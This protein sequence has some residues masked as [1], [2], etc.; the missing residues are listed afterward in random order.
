MKLKNLMI[1]LVALFSTSQ[2]FA[3]N[4]VKN[5]T[6]SPSSAGIE[7]NQVMSHPLSKAEMTKIAKAEK[8]QVKAQKKAAFFAKL[9][10]KIDFKD[11]VE[12]WLWFGIFGW[13]ASILLYILAY[14]VP[15]L[16]IL[17]ALAGLFGTVCI[18]IW[19]IKK[20]G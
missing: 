1:V 12:K 17:G 15:F 9:A 16:W 14:A 18:V 8:L 2:I 10:K 20:F 11:P 19:L 3:V 6:T 7:I 13:G 4:T 5:L